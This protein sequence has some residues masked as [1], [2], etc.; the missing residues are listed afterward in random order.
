MI[1]VA[2]KSARKRNSGTRLKLHRVL[3]ELYILKKILVTIFSGGSRN[4]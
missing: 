2:P 1:L 3:A 4:F